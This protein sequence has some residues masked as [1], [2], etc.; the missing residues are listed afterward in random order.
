MPEIEIRPATLDDLTDL[1]F[2]AL[3]TGNSGSDATS[4][5][6]NDQMLGEVFVGP[7]VTHASE[8][9]NLLSESGKTIGYG[10]CVLDTDLFQKL[11]KHWWPQLQIKY[12]DLKQFSK[13][14][15][16][17]REIFSPTPSPSE[18]LKDF[19]SHGH[20]DLLPQVQGKGWGRKL[21]THMENQLK[22]LGSPGFHLRV[23]AYNERGLKF[24]A[25]LGYTELLKR[26]DEV[27]VGKR[28]SL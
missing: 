28:L 26:G 3:K 15:W 4:L 2:V 9:S 20:I 13:D 19:P 17:I 12:A 21:M 16:L 18:V 11:M 6:R 5:F 27:V 8:T 14:E 7:Y 24:Y 1:Y 23:S 22:D 10:L 25:A